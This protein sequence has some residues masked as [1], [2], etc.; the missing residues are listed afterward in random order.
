MKDEWPD[1]KVVSDDGYALLITNIH[2]G[3]SYIYPIIYHTKHEAKD[4]IN[5]ILQSTKNNSIR[6]IQY[7]VLNH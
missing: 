2:T 4:A 3:N 6:V 7:Q 5:G 1:G